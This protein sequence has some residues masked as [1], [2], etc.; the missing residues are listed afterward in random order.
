MR[1]HNTNTGVTKL[2]KAA[3]KNL[4][5]TLPLKISLVGICFFFL[6]LLYISIEPIGLCKMY[7]GIYSQCTPCLLLNSAAVHKQKECFTHITISV[8]PSNT[9]DDVVTL[10]V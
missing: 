6:G 10:E 4:T 3:E 7:M 1:T 2:G 8:S 9:V 5:E